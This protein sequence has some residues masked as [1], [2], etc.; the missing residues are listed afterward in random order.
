[1]KIILSR[2]GFDAEYG[3]Q[4]S[5]ILP[6]GTLIS[7]PIPSRYD[8]VKYTDLHHQGET[9]YKILKD[10][11]PN[12]KIKPDYNCHLD[13]DLRF[14]TTNR[15]GNWKPIFGQVEAAQKHLKNQNVSIGDIF[16][17][18]G[19]FR[20]TQ[21]INGKYSYK[22]ESPDLHLIYGYLQI[23]E[24][25]CYENTFPDYADHH[26]H[27]RERLLNVPSNCIYVGRETLTFDETL[28][29]A[30]NFRFNDNLVLTKKGMTRSKWELP[31]FF[32]T[33]D[34]S[35]HTKESFKE[36]YFQSAAKG[37]E[38]VIPA[39]NNLIEWTKELIT[40]NGLY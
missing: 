13:P 30:G 7:M 39:D 33:L 4:P 9:Y 12:I 10:L 26:P 8:V 17:F 11:K 24:I 23:G 21:I 3:G 5:P 37:Q 36:N 34:I 35:Y 18:F 28:P 2:K 29:G 20:Q 22:H 19:W 16:L 25:Y 6:D 32:K 31:G 40:K 27:A 14:A 1:M 15:E 38:F